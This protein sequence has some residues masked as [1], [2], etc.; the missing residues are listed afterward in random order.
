MKDFGRLIWLGTGLVLGL[1]LTAIVMH[2]KAV[3]ICV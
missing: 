3:C 2:F 1:V